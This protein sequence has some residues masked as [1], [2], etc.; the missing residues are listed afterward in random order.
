M[1]CVI[2]WRSYQIG[3]AQDWNGIPGQ[4]WFGGGTDI[5]PA[6]LDADDMRHFHG[7]YKVPRPC[8]YCL[9]ADPVTTLDT[10]QSPTWV[11]HDLLFY[12][13]QH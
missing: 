5:T 8:Q 4:W 13:L 6:Y 1:W 2:L 9:F 12:V 11:V 7:C 10:R 3:A